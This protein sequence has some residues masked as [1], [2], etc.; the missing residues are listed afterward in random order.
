METKKVYN[1]LEYKI[2][3]AYNPSYELHFCKCD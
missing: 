1:P 2:V 3:L